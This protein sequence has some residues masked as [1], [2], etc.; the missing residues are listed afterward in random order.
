MVKQTNMETKKMQFDDDAADDADDDDD[1]DD[2]KNMS[3]IMIYI[4]V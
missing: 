1:V 2:L 4:Y 3:N